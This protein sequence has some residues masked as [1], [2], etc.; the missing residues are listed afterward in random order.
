M[1]PLSEHLAYHLIPHVQWHS[2]GGYWSV[3][4]RQNQSFPVPM[5]CT[6]DQVSCVTNSN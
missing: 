4:Y 5:N 3:W 1:L 6:T 2:Q